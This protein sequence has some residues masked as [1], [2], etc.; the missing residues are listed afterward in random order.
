MNT[1][2]FQKSG[3]ALLLALT[4]GPALS[5]SGAAHGQTI[6]PS[7]EEQTQLAE[8]REA[9]LRGDRSQIPAMIK[10]LTAR[11]TAYHIMTA[12]RALSELQATE[13]LPAINELISSRK[14]D[15]ATGFARVVRARIVAE[16]S[17]DTRTAMAMAK[18]RGVSAG[19]S[20]DTAAGLQAAAGAEATLNRFLSLLN[21]NVAKL[22]AATTKQNAKGTS[23]ADID[24]ES[25]ATYAQEEIADM[26]LRSDPSYAALAMVKTLDYSADP[27]AALKLKLAPMTHAARVQWLIADLSRKKRYTSDEEEE[28]QLA[29][30][31][32]LPAS[33]LAVDTLKIMSKNQNSYAGMGFH[34]LFRVIDGVWDK[35]DQPII[36]TFAKNSDPE[37]IHSSIR[38]P[39]YKRQAAAG[40]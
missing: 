28:A 17:T 14:G 2:R 10:A 20:N 40:F 32:G 34:S 38:V 24:P 25:I 35:T 6:Q 11:P 1:K 21:L 37:V 23:A 27:G 18:N 5:L 30:D 22:R 8:M 26:A 19:L 15:Y 3:A 29:I 39:H 31:E 36:A 12:L 33:R 9:A 7:L 13:V 4:I 16:T